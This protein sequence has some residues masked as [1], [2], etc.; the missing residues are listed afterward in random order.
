MQH[1][2]DDDTDG[3]AAI[4]SE[5]VDAGYSDDTAHPQP[6]TDD[7]ETALDRADDE[8]PWPARIDWCRG[9]RWSLTTLAGTVI[10]FL[11]VTLLTISEHSPLGHD[12]SVYA[13]RGR[14][15]A[16]GLDNGTGYWSG[17]RA[18]GIPFLLG[19]VYRA[20]RPSDVLSRLVIV[21]FGAAAIIIVFVLATAMAD[22]RAGAAAAVLLVLSSGFTRYAA[23]IFI[24]VP[25]MTLSMAAVTAAYLLWRNGRLHPSA[26][27]V[28][29]LLAMAGTYI[30]F[31]APATLAPGLV[32]IV[33]VL[34]SQ[35]L[36][37][38]A[39][40]FVLE[41]IGLAAA[42]G[43]AM[44]LV[45]LIPW[46]TAQG[47][48]P[49][50]AQQ[51]FRDAKGIPMLD[52]VSD[53]NS[54]VWPS[55]AREDFFHP[56]VFWTI[57]ALLLIAVVSTIR[58]ERVRPIVVFGLIGG[59]GTIVALNV[60]LSLIQTQYLVLAIPYVV[61]VAGAGFSVT[62]DWI[63]GWNLAVRSLFAITVVVVVAFST[64]ALKDRL[65]AGA[66]SLEASYGPIRDSGL[67]VRALGD[68]DCLV[69]TGTSPQAGW[70][71]Q[72]QMS[73]WGRPPA[74]NP[75]EFDDQLQNVVASVGS[76]TTVYA[77]DVLK[78]KREPASKLFDENANLLLVGTVGT[79]DDGGRR[80]VRIFE[81]D[82]CIT[83]DSCESP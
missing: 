81:V 73:P 8:S 45:L 76:G 72:C 38:R 75:R 27:I 6:P 4:D 10:V 74:T 52:S 67:T 25:G 51:A 54:I 36:R 19:L 29:P 40:A 9:N 80:Y 31:G 61:I 68:D 69:L 5:D 64:V 42:T 47:Q 63:D 37:Y 34:A 57:V 83:D 35:Q 18:P 13:N 43:L 16:G 44:G 78:G 39:R 50:R 21:A 55:G 28:V 15:F 33:V 71:A 7:V 17:F 70:Y 46:F 77:I 22:A 26:Y 60:N 24:D 41:V 48:S 1:M 49:L 66:A 58:L 59:I 65:H 56:L 11:T 82:E 79:P 30:R 2:P 23:L 14:F 12:E 53:F 32:A 3:A 62:L 20:F